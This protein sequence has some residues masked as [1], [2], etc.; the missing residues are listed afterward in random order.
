MALKQ[1]V[2]A[3]WPDCTF[4]CFEQHWEMILVSRLEWN[5]AVVL[6]SD[7]LEPIL[8]DLPILRHDHHSLRKHTHSYIALAATGK[9][10]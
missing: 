4:L 2:V 1:T 6:P 10:Y 7:F 5:L 9:Q 8:A 3:V